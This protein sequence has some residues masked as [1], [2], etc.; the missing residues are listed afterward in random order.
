LTASSRALLLT[1]F[2]VLSLVAAAAPAQ[3]RRIFV[4]RQY[5]GLQNAIDAASKGD[6]V[7]VGK[8]VYRGTIYI[9]KPLVLFGDAGP[10]S[11][12]RPVCST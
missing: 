9:R 2:A 8:G 10:D 1:A 3:A 6:T 12:I 4:P 5:K 7:W 11:T